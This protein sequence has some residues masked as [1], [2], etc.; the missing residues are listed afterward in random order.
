MSAEHHRRVRWPVLGLVVVLAVACEG[1]PG[2]DGPA[3]ATGPTGDD[4]PDGADGADGAAGADGAPGLDGLSVSERDDDGDGIL[5][6]ED[7]DDTD[8]SAG[9]AVTL[10]LD[11][12]GDGF[13]DPVL[14]TV[15]CFY[16]NFNF[17]IKHTDDIS[18]KK[19]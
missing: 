8:P 19:N 6:G 12:D 2:K 11:Y 17:I 15:T 5:A 16:T 3:G 18:L 4:G 1:L 10:H 7:C 14:T 13:G 9:R